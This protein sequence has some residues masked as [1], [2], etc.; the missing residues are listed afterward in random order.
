MLSESHGI[1]PFVSVVIPATRESFVHSVNSALSQTLKPLEI[2]V[3]D[4]S[5]G[6]SLEFV[7]E[8][9]YVLKTGGLKGV[10]FSRNLGVR[11][12]LG[13]WIAFLDD[14]DYWLSSKLELQIQFANIHSLDATYTSCL[15]NSIDEVRPRCNYFRQLSPLAQIY[16]FGFRLN[17]R[18]YLGFSSLIIKR[19]A[20][21]DTLFDETMRLREDLK[22]IQEIWNK[23]CSIDL[24]AEILCVIDYNFMRSS[25]LIKLE[26]DLDWFI[27]LFK[28]SK[29]VALR[30]FVLNIV[31]N[32]FIRMCFL[33]RRN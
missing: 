23:G 19:S 16:D 30:F 22:F 26:N 13:Q 31:R 9:V 7:G 33:L 5:K 8:N 3:V 28:V 29:S 15:L 25:N 21:G 4:D 2:I 12:S 27:Y 6:Q 17:S 32:R 10:S 18:F 20:I 11:A 1:K 24:L 14:D